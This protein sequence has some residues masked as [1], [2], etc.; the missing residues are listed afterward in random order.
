MSFFDRFRKKRQP[1][2]VP[3]APA[4]TLDPESYYRAQDARTKV[5]LTAKRSVRLE[6]GKA[7]A[8]DRGV[9]LAKGGITLAKKFDGA[10]VSLAKVN[11][12]GVRAEA[13]L[14]LDHSRSM[15]GDYRNGTVQAIVERA[16]GFALQIDGDGKIPVIPFDSHVYPAV[17]VTLQNFGDIVNKRLYHPDRMSRT[18]LRDALAE[19]LELAKTTDAPLFVIVV[20]DGQPDDVEGVKRLARE[21]SQYP[22]FLKFLAVDH[23]P[24]LDELDNSLTGRLVDNINS[25]YLGR[26]VANMEDEDFA[27]AMV[28]E[29]ASW[30]RDALAANVLL[31]L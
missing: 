24:F 27:D 8:V 5:A 13:V 21:L 28:E 31:P 15:I 29:W 22:V 20:T 16:L 11:L 30:T 4:P 9:V 26:G 7:P 18:N 14:V 2:P 12:D 3:E 6:R 25:Q 17:E 10:G 19:V 23:F 1:V